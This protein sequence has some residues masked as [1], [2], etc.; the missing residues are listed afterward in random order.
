MHE[1]KCTM[2][3]S[4]IAEV[5][6]T[7]ESTVQWN[8]CSHGLDWSSNT[9]NPYWA[10]WAPTYLALLTLLPPPSRAII[11]CNNTIF[12]LHIHILYW[13]CLFQTLY[14]F[15]Y[16]S[17]LQQGNTYT[18]YLNVYNTHLPLYSVHT[19]LLYIMHIAYNPFYIHSSL[20]SKSFF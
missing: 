2:R 11:L 18:V 6:F 17:S 4:S 20:L 19:Y 15:I 1:C 13:V 10:P 14:L 12:F 7:C 5:N 3:H 9:S 8:P 16:A